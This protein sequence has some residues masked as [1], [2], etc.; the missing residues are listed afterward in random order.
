[1]VVIVNLLPTVAAFIDS[2]MVPLPEPLVRSPPKLR[3][4]RARNVDD[5]FVPKRSA[6][7]AAKSQFR[8][9]KPDAQARK[10]MMKKLG[11]PVETEQPDQASFEEFQ[12]T[13]RSPLSSCQRAG[14]RELFPGRRSRQPLS[15]S[16]IAA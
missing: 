3:V 13:F 1:M 14:M 6:R 9:N 8:A 15:E 5:S 12:E 10:I 2:V 7:L 16:E 4:T 11:V